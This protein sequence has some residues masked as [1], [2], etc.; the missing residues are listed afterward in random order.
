MNIKGTLVPD[1][2][3]GLEMDRHPERHVDGLRLPS[4][5]EAVKTYKEIYGD[6]SLKQ[7]KF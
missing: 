5:D 3:Q 2:L 6:G 7:Y 4:E 1:D